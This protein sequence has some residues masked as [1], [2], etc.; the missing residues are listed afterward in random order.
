MKKRSTFNYE[1]TSLHIWEFL[2]EYQSNGH[3]RN[4]IGR[5]RKLLN[6]HIKTE[7][8]RFKTAYSQVRKARCISIQI[9]SRA[10]LCAVSKTEKR[11]QYVPDFMK[12]IIDTSD[13]FKNFWLN[14][15]L[16]NLPSVK[17]LELLELD[18]PLLNYNTLQLLKLD[19]FYE[20]FPREIQQRGEREVQ[21]AE[22]NPLNDK[23]EFSENLQT[24]CMVG[25]LFPFHVGKSL[26]SLLQ[27]ICNRS[28]GE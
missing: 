5:G 20:Y 10:H 15:R 9:F 16:G 7:N 3:K 21:L 2:V 11:C 17:N 25:S 28:S 24:D 23:M 8:R 12:C 13:D 22:S 26:S 27:T 14:Q 6:S 18:I 4:F 1:K 19:Q